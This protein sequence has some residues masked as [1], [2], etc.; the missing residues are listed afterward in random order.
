MKPEE[1]AR[2]SRLRRVSEA[3]RPPERVF[4]AEKPAP[5][6]VEAD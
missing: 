6:Q 2:S 5:P 1:W 3:L 4:K